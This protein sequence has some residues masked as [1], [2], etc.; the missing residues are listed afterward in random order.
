MKS[1][2]I[3]LN[4]IKNRYYSVFCLILGKTDGFTF[5][6]WFYE[7]KPWTV[8]RR[9]SRITLEKSE[10]LFALFSTKSIYWM[11]LLT[12]FPRLAVWLWIREFWRG[13]V[14]LF[15]S[16]KNSCVSHHQ[17][18]PISTP[19]LWFKFFLFNYI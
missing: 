10:K 15:V 13:Q 14:L 5:N 19:N 17:I 6:K 2:S 16:G 7:R 1:G 4:F 11:Q 18:S 12:V 8:T 3:L 9:H